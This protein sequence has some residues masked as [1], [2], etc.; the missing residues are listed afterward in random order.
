VRWT[1][2]SALRLNLR[3]LIGLHTTDFRSSPCD[4]PFESKSLRLNSSMEFHAPTRFLL[5]MVGALLPMAFDNLGL[6][7]YCHKDIFR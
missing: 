5:G 1:I 3:P 7:L 4:H 6:I 2:L